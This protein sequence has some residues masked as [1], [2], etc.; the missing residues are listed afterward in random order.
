GVVLGLVPDDRA[1]VGFSHPAV[2]TVA[3]VLVLSRG[4][5]V[6]GATDLIA[7]R[8]LPRREG[9]GQIAAL[10]FIGAA[11]SSV[12]NNVGALAL[13]L[14]VASGSSLPPGRIMM[15]LA[16]TTILGGMIT[17]IGTPPNLIVA[18]VRGDAGGEP[19]G[20]FAF[21]PVGLTV[22]AAGTLFIALIGWRLVPNRGRA[23]AAGRDAF[24]ME[25]YLAEVRVAESSLA[26]DKTIAQLD[27]LIADLDVK[28]IGLIRSGRRVPAVPRL[29][30]LEAGD[31]LMI[32]ALPRD[33]QPFVRKLR[34]EPVDPGAPMTPLLQSEDVGLV[35]AIVTPGSKLESRTALSARLQRQ[36]GVNLLAVSRQGRPYRGRLRAFR[37]EAGDVLLLQGE[38]DR[39]H[40]V[41]GSLGCLPLAER[42]LKP[43]PRSKEQSLA[44]LGCFLGGIALAASGLFSVAVSLAAGATMLLVLRVLH[45]RQ[46][47]EAIDWPVIVLL[48]ALIPLGE[49]LQTSGAATMIADLLLRLTDGQAPWFV[50]AL[51]M[52]ATCA[53][54]NVLNNAAT[55]VVMAPLA[56]DLARALEAN[57]DSFLMGVAIS[58]SCAFLTPIGHQN[59]ALVMGPGGYKFADYWR[60]GLPLSVLVLT[61]G[62][63]MILWIW[64]L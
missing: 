19:F 48:S 52:G 25:D 58:A 59:N 47:Y 12:M 22:A 42:G 35:E 56:V 54:T 33:L 62:L 46:A 39:L 32:E 18:A 53:L 55:A 11:F 63:L 7:R 49:A 40:D 15:P 1:F 45:M 57:P 43:P 34:L 16:F 44:A 60:L 50:L 8:L 14:P 21:L 36:Y 29:E 37:F 28:I 3:A 51:L 27:P 41:V 61:V 38:A 9:A 13:L 64:P 10:G 2:V 4:L 20:M 31:I 26:I 5:S 23:H 30:R 6:S 24:E 17:L